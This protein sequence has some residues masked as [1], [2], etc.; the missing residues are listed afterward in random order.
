MI[1][2]IQTNRRSVVLKINSI[3]KKKQQNKS[4]WS[5]KASFKIYFK[6]LKTHSCLTLSDDYYFVYFIE[7]NI[8]FNNLNFVLS[9]A[10]VVISFEVGCFNVSI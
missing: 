6:Y 2:A 3:L 9:D 4:K 1:N 8:I 7:L 5:F 10:Y